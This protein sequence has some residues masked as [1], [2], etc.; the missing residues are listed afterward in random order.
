VPNP[1]VHFEILGNDAAGL[2]QYY[3]DLFDWKITNASQDFPYG[4]IDA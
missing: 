1:I 3:R 4:I 2:Q